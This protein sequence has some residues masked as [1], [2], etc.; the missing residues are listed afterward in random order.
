M[1]TTLT[2]RVIKV[3]KTN[4]KVLTFVTKG[5]AN[6]SPDPP[7]VGGLVQGRVIWHA[8]YVGGWLMWAKTW[9]GIAVLVYLP[10]LFIMIHETNL[11]ASYLRKIKPYRLEGWPRV[12]SSQDQPSLWPKWAMAAGTVVSIVVIIIA[13]WQTAE[14]LPS[15]SSQTLIMLRSNT[16]SAHKVTAR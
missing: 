10:A 3:Y 12:Q 13:S 6:P 5:D 14:A 2:H 11:L 16:I 15:R 7:V 9:T 4:G 1:R 8:P